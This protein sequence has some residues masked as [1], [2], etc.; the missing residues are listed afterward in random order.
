[1]PYLNTVHFIFLVKVTEDKLRHLE[2]IYLIE[3]PT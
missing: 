2:K 1:M 3:Y